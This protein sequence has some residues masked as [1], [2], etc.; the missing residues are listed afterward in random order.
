MNFKTI[1]ECKEAVSKYA[2][3]SNIVNASVAALW[4]AICSWVVAIW[5]LLLICT[6]A[7]ILI[8]D[9]NGI[10]ALHAAFTILCIGITMSGA[11]KYARDKISEQFINIRVN[12]ASECF[13][14]YEGYD[15]LDDWEKRKIFNT[16]IVKA[17]DI[18][19]INENNDDQSTQ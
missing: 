19:N 4:N 16:E 18:R 14:H 17:A 15:K 13:M 3:I 6:P 9:K 10:A 2:T 1:D 7:Y 11:S 8:A 12:I 5:T